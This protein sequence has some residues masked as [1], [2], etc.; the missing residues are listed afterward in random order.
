MK[1]II[2][3]VMAILTIP[4][5]CNA[6]LTNSCNAYY[7]F[8]DDWLDGSQFDNQATPLGNPSFV[9][10]KKGKAVFLDGID[11]SIILGLN[12][13][14]DQLTISFWI[15]FPELTENWQTLI[16]MYDETTIN[17]VTHLK[18]TFYLK[19]LGE[20]NDYKIYFSVSENGQ[21]SIDIISNISITSKTWYHI[22]ACFQKGNILLYIDGK[23]EN[24]KQTNFQQLYTS[25]VPTLLGAMYRNGIESKPFANMIMDEL[26]LY[27]RTLSNLEI[28]E[29]YEIKPGPKILDH[30]PKGILRES[31]SHV[32][33][34]FDKPIISKLFT[35]DDILM[36]GPEQQVI[37]VD[38]PE[39]L[40]N[41]LYRLGFAE[42]SATGI[43]TV[44]IG[45]HILDKAG[46]EMDQDQDDIN[47]EQE[48]IYNAEFQ[49]NVLPDNVLLVNFSG[50]ASDF[51]SHHIYETLVEAGATV[52]YANLT[53]EKSE[54]ILISL[55]QDVDKPYQQVWVFDSSTNDGF[56]PYAIDAIRDWYLSKDNRHIICDGRMRAS[57][58]TGQW[59]TNGQLLTNNYY[60]NLKLNGGGLLLATDHPDD[61]PD[62]NS[63]CEKIN[64]T[65]FGEL[66]GYKTV[67]TD[68]SCSIMSYPNELGDVLGT[69]SH[70][71]KV[72]F[73]KQPNGA[74]LFCIAWDPDNS[75]SCSIS[76]T[77]TPLIPT[78]ISS[79]KINNIIELTWSPAKPENK[80]SHYNIYVSDKQISSISGIK[81]YQTDIYQT[82]TQLISLQTGKTYYMAVTA[83]D[84]SGKERHE[85]FSISTSLGSPRKS[86]GGDGSGGCFLELID[87]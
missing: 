66:A 7:S 31:I 67:K 52:V 68:S 50:Q 41:S 3:L 80:V 64:I 53:S 12:N 15:K 13:F 59:Q 58:W 1:K 70:S 73:G 4:V 16:S 9:E 6:T 11:D 8:N 49:L 28:K 63:I 33:I 26:R 51:D 83:V 32:D 71:S 74:Y 24:E 21:Q 19:L 84:T 78:N 37:A 62:I 81:P 20:N 10:G 55:L 48:D 5:L 17:E 39:Q 43:Y 42:Q 34:L 54:N 38:E 77:I 86:S 82:H 45:P 30:M 22:V 56:Y 79:Q 27:N 87:Y 85:V 44:E 14:I 60:E 29:L 75:S 36:T 18:H 35:S 57:Y 23:K 72:S 40:S 61:H 47:G 46:N 2:P 25:T 69:T 65:K 76:T